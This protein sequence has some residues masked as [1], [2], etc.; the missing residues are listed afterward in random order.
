MELIKQYT[1]SLSF[2]FQSVDNSNFDETFLNIKNDNKEKL[3]PILKYVDSLLRLTFDTDESEIK[4]L[5]INFSTNLSYQERDLIAE[6]LL[7][8][9]HIDNVKYKSGDLE[10]LE[11]EIN[12]LT[13]RVNNFCYP[14]RRTREY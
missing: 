4:T 3:V 6:Y 1:N 7:L 8:K 9:F 11:N 10:G 14:A 12:I 2:L 5:H 13:N